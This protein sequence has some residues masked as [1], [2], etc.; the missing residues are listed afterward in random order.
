MSDFMLILSSLY[1]MTFSDS[2]PQPPPPP[3]EVFRGFPVVFRGSPRIFPGFS[4]GLPGV[5]PGF[6]RGFP[7]VFPGFSRGFPRVFPGFSQAFFKICLK[8]IMQ[9]LFIIIFFLD[10]SCNLS[11]IVSVLLSASVERFFVS[12]MRDFF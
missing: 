6:S 4:R 5:F 1:C 9:S 11:K 12:H 8:K 3:P 10:K 2:W 7:G